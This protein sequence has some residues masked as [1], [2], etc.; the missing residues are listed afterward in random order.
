MMCIFV[1]IFV[2]IQGFE[3]GAR[4]YTK[5]PDASGDYSYGSFVQVNFGNSTKVTRI[6]IR[7][8]TAPYFDGHS[9]IGTLRTSYSFDDI[10]WVLGEDVCIVISAKYFFKKSIFIQNM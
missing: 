2:Y 10:N 9:H 3:L 4:S 8:P 7:H 1:F 5:R 6:T